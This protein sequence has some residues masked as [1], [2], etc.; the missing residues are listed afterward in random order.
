MSKKEIRYEY[1]NRQIDSKIVTTA[2]NHMVGAFHKDS[3][4]KV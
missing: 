4:A 3:V 1:G 2:M